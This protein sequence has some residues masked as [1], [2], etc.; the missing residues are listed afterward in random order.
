MFKQS[1]CWRQL[2]SLRYHH[3]LIYL[4]VPPSK[5]DNWM[6]NKKLFGLFWNVTASGLWSLL[7]STGAN[8]MRQNDCWSFWLILFAGV[9]VSQPSQTLNENGTEINNNISNVDYNTRT[10]KNG[11]VHGNT[12]RLPKSE[13]S[14]V[15]FLA[16]SYR[17]EINLTPENV[18]ITRTLT[19][20]N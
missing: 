3:I 14:N 9:I 2:L 1:D 11:Q 8:K 6:L 15:N 10:I 13:I 4:I 17:Y 18:L 12:P 7:H 5:K 20:G 19:K 16:I